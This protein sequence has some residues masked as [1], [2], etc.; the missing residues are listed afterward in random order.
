MDTQSVIV[1]LEPDPDLAAEDV[2]RLHR[3]LRIELGELDVDAVTTAA[4]EPA[5]DG[6]KG[7]DPATVGA[8]LVALSTSGGVF[9]ALVYTLRDWLSRQP[10]NHRVRIT[11]DG[12]TL[13][14]ERATS[15]EQRLLVETFTRRH[16]AEE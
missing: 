8:I 10:R 14:L 7:V 2:E 4:G 3:Q 11:I 15:E 6:A 13:A 12:E 5:P 9:T 1:V 16:G